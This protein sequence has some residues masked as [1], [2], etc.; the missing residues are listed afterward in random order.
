MPAN[1]FPNHISCLQN[2]YRESNSYFCRFRR[3]TVDLN[4]LIS[5]PIRTNTVEKEKK[6][7]GSQR[8]K[9]FFL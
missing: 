5:R 7:H 4:L 3:V 9:A 1:F 2:D 8:T 6:G